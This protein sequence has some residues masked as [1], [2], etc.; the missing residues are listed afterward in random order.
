MPP[1]LLAGALQAERVVQIPAAPNSFAERQPCRGF[2]CLAGSI[3]VVK[4]APE[5]A[6]ML[7]YRVEPG[8]SCIITSSC[9][10]GQADYNA[11]GIAETP[12]PAVLPAPPCSAG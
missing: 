3:K 8:G 10:L 2:C 6:R 7:L 11:H 12:H 5:R 1:A 9:L 4:S